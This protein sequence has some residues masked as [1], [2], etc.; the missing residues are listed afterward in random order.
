MV[1]YSIEPFGEVQSEYRAALV[2]STMANTARDTEKR[3]QPFDATE[4]MRPGYL[5]E[6]ENE[7]SDQ[8]MLM[9]KAKMIFGLL[10]AKP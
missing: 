10:G 9:N 4:F 6:Q 3:K 5:G 1:Y 7:Q 8:E 2:A